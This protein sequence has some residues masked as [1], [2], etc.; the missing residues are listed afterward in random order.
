MSTQIVDMID[1]TS[2]YGLA[3]INKEDCPLQWIDGSVAAADKLMEHRF[4]LFALGEISLGDDIDFN[5]EYKN[6]I[7]TPLEF[8]PWLDYRDTKVFGDFKYFW[9]VPRFQHLI[10]LSKAYYL[11][12][13][14]E[15]ADE[16]V[17]QLEEFIK[18][19]PYL[20]GVNWTMPMESGIRL[21]S[22]SWIVAFLK[23]YLRS[24]PEKCALI[25]QVIKSHLH[26]ITNNYAAFSSANNHLVGEAAGAFVASICFFGMEGMGKVRRKAYDILCREIIHQHYSDGVNKEQAVHYQIFCFEFF[27][28]S[29]LLGRA[30]GIDFPKEYWEMLEKSASFISAVTNEDLSIKQIGDSD[31]GK[32]IVLSEG[33]YE[34]A[35]SI[36]ATS[37]VLFDRIDF[38]EKAK[39]FDEKSFWLLGKK[40]KADFDNI[41][42][43]SDSKQNPNSFSEGGYYI[44]GSDGPKEVKII[45]DCGPLG[46]ESIAAHGHADS[47]SFTLDAY[48]KEFLIDPGTYTYI[49]DDPFRN[50]FRSTSAHNTVVIDGQDQSEIAGPFIWKHKAR[51][52]IKNFEDNG[53]IVRVTGWHDGYEALDDPVVHERSLSLSKEKGSLLVEDIFRCDGSH[54]VTL[55]FHFSRSC[56]IT[57]TSERNY[58]INNGNKSIEL[59][60]DGMLTDTLILGDNDTLSGWSSDKYDQKFSIYTLS[61]CGKITGRSVIKTAINL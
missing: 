44:L 59:C 37:S 48:G 33:Q 57:R 39:V 35:H 12:G 28:I 9:E 50:Y 20:L 31:D 45:F 11:T 6:K 36:L 55:N 26:H 32:V 27:L 23:D 14:N 16:V 51:S 17:K 19:C 41:K 56:S 47:L 49:A 61:C 43:L 13:K 52:F 24:R 30:N 29:A 1:N 54:E 25:E 46:F 53:D 60:V 15:Y 18:Q 7:K 58:Q 34:E 21:I 22:I 4:E 2:F 3:D 42:K 38:A 40:G 8:G 5:Y 10:T